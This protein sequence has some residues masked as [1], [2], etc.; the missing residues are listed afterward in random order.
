LKDNTWG[1]L[2]GAACAM[3]IVLALRLLLLSICGI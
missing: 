2:A 3:L 1:L